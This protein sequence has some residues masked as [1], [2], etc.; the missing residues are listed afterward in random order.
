MDHHFM[1]YA[2]RGVVLVSGQVN[3]I[4]RCI[5][6]ATSFN[7][8]LFTLLARSGIR[9]PRMRCCF[10]KLGSPSIALGEEAFEKL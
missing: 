2:A 10:K 9:E 7:G 8:H 4:F 1:R 5:P 6:R 3:N